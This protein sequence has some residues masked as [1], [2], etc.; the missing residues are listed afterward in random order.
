MNTFNYATK[1]ISRI[2]LGTG[3]F[4]TRVEKELAFEMLDYF[5]QNGGNVVDTARNYYEWVENG[6]G[7]SELC[8]GEW[9]TAR[10]NRDDICLCTKGGVRNEGNVFISNLS[11][12]A[13]L[14]EVKESRDALQTDYIDMYLLH[15]DEPERSVEEI[16]ETM[17]AIKEAGNVS[18]I[19]VANWKIDRVMAANDYAVTH[20]MEPFRIV[21]TWWSLA[22]YTES[23]WNDPTTT[24]MDPKTYEYMR[25]HQ[26]L[27]M[28]YTSQCKGF[29]Q[30]AYTHGLDLIDPFLMKRIATPT[31]I[32][33]FEYIK[34]YC[35]K[36]MVSPTAVVN[37]YITS[38]PLNGIALVSVSNMEQ[39][40]DIMSVCDYCLEENVIHELDAIVS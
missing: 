23:M 21:Q 1:H 14:T 31:N 7:M 5:Y 34:K 30:K 27:G 9:M 33:K 6:R 26:I 13:L 36:N 28:A 15:R 37:G 22:E 19:G 40:K 39:L 35:D 8:I 16:V 4:G 38:N 12:D 24:H 20:E 25:E 3:R 17:Q 29:F 18:T 10:G 11:K 2:G 32:K